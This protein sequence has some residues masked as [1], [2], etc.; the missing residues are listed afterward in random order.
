[1]R[2][3]QD[4]RNAVQIGGQGPWLELD[5]SRPEWATTELVAA[6]QAMQ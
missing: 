2:L 1:M 4:L 6:I 3:R 5:A